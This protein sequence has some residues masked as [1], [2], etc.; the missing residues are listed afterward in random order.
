MT[1]RV[2][3]LDHINPLTGLDHSF[4]A[5]ISTRISNDSRERV[6]IVLSIRSNRV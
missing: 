4:Y 3:R 1:N 6:F 2:V 5:K